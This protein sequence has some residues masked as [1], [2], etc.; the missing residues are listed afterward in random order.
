MNSM[1]ISPFDE[2]HR[3]LQEEVVLGL[4]EAGFLVAETYHANIPEGMIRTIESINTPTSL[5]LRTTPD[6]VA[7]HPKKETVS[8]IELK[9][10]KGSCPNMAIEAMP[11]MFHRYLARVSIETWLVYRDSINPLDIAFSVKEMPIPDIL[12]VPDRWDRRIE[13]F[14]GRFARK[15][16]PQIEIRKMKVNGSGDPFFVFKRERLESLNLPGWKEAIIQGVGL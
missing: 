10:R 9:T 12:I 11:M 13:S 8:R 16:F 3:K 2:N 15:F 7:V 14:C 5:Y 1:R 6:L 4:T